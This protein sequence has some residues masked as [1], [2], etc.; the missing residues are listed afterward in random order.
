MWIIDPATAATTAQAAAQTVSP[1]TDLWHT[2]L[3]AVAVWLGNFVHKLT[4]GS[5]N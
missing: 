5:D 4:S 1:F 3:V 2:V